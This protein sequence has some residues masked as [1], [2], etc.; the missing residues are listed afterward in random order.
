MA[1][2]RLKALSRNAVLATTNLVCMGTYGVRKIT[3][4]SFGMDTTRKKKT[5]KTTNN[6]NTGKFK[7]NVNKKSTRR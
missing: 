7:S 1:S 3:M 2:R 5:W 4:K 6:M